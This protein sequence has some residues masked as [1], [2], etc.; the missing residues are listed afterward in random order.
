MNSAL[1]MKKK[2][3]RADAFLF[4]LLGISHIHEQ[5]LHQAGGFGVQEGVAG[6]FDELLAY[7]KQL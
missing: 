1:C 2:R 6:S 7:I 3:I 4:L 5:R